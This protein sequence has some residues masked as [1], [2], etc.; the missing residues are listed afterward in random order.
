MAFMN[1]PWLKFYPS[2]WR[3][4]PRL[5][6]CSLAARGLWIDL[7]SY[8]HEGEPY[9]YLMIDGSSPSVDDVSALVGRPRKEVMQALNE[10][11]SRLVFSRSETG[12][13]YSRRMVR[14][15]AKADRDCTNGKAG[16]NPGL[17]MGVNPPNKGEDKA[18][19]LEARIPEA[20][21]EE[22]RAGALR[23]DWPSQYRQIFWSIYPHKVGKTYALKQLDKLAKS[24]DGPSF[25]DLIA[26]L[27]RYCAKTDDRPWCNPATWL[28]QGRW[29]D[30]PAARNE[31]EKHG[32]IIEAADQL[33]ASFVEFGLAPGPICDGTGETF[34][35][36]ISERRGE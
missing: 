26:A 14:D 29:T 32:G 13:I 5:R 19:K 35:R 8:M 12:I 18:Q 36:P 30:Q 17:I 2:D 21:K 27:R 16:G 31:H 34:V 1:R 24:R 7:I 22:T 33:R 11:E 3:A 20:R 25:E 15:K 28:N 6:M 9:G 4:D 23:S 10:L